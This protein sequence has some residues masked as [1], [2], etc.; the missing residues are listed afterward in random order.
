MTEF[1]KRYLS[2]INADETNRGDV[3]RYQ[4]FYVI[5]RTDELWKNVNSLY[6]FSKHELKA[7]ARKGLHGRVKLMMKRTVHLYNG[8]GTKDIDSVTLYWGLDDYN[9]E[10]MIN[11]QRIFLGQYDFNKEML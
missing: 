9:A 10:T 4:L 2:M 5:A 11:A 1:K 6:D 8:G 3:E 7:G